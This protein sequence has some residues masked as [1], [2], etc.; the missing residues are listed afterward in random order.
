MQLHEPSAT[1]SG[2]HCFKMAHVLGVDLDTGAYI[3]HGRWKFTEESCEK[4]LPEG[5]EIPK[6][7]N[8]YLIDPEAM[9]F[10]SEDGIPKGVL[11][12]FG[13]GAGV[14]LSGY[15]H[16]NMNCRMLQNLIMYACG[17]NITQDFI[18]DNCNVECAWYPEADTMIIVNNTTI[19]QC[20]HISVYGK[21]FEYIL[22]GGEMKKISSWN[23]K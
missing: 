6:K 16:N 23:M 3:R 12:R 19:E 21:E 10:K 4:L 9:V 13:K 22:K 1:D 11:H 18:P 5:V 20:A 17:D 15:R 7:N 2:D 14:Y 8:I